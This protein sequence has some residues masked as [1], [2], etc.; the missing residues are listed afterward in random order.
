MKILSWTSA[1]LSNPEFDEAWEK[2]ENAGISEQTLQIVTGINGA[3]VETL[4]DIAR[5]AFMLDLEDL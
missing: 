1:D 2:L 4:N 3:T 5:C